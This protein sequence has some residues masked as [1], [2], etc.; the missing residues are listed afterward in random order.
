MAQMVQQHR[1]QLV[2][3]S[4]FAPFVQTVPQGHPATAHLLGKILPGNAGLEHKEDSGKTDPI[5]HARLA[6]LGA[7]NMLGKQR[8]NDPPKLIRDQKPGHDGFLHEQMP[9]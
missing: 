5:R 9:S 7:G 2:P 1:V 4:S 6:A 3:N 8:L